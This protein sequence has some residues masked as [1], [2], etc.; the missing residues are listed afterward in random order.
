MKAAMTGSAVMFGL[1]SIALAMG[2]M[3][4]EFTCSAALAAFSAAAREAFT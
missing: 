4:L 2:D 1:L 3:R